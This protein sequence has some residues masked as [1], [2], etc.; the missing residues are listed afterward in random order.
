MSDENQRP[1]DPAAPEVWHRVHPL[2]P[3]LDSLGVLVAIVI[4]AAYAAQ[5]LV[6]NALEGLATGEGVDLSFAGWLRSHPLV[7]LA[8]VG[9][10]VLV[11]L[12]GGLISWLA[13]KVMGYRLEADALY[14]RSGLFVKKQRKARLDRVQSI[15]L[16]QKLL[17][18]VFGL[19]ELV[20]DVAGGSD[21]N[22]SLKYLSRRRA[23]VLRDELLAAV[24]AVKEDRSTAPAGSSTA[25]GPGAGS[26]T[27]GPDDGPDTAVETP[28]V[29]TSV[30]ERRGDSVGV[31]VTKRL[32]AIAGGAVGEVEDSLNEMLA[33]YQVSTR[34]G[35]EGEIIR[36]P[37][38]RVVLA[39]LLKTETLITVLIFLGMFVAVGVLLVLGLTEVAIPLLFGVIPG[40]FAA[41]ATVRKDFANA[42][43]AVRMTDSGLAVSHGLFSVSRKVIP[44]DRVQAVCLHQPF[45]WRF[46]GWWR[47][48]YNIASGSDS[49]D[50]NL[51]LPV[52]DIDQALLMIGLALPDPQVADGIDARSLILS[53]MYDRRSTEP[54]AEAAE[55]RFSRQPR[56]SRL[57]DP[58]VYRR[59]AYT[60]TPAL[61]ILRLGALERRVDFV[62]HERVQSMQY[63]QGPLMRALGLGSVAVHSTAGP[64]RPQVTHQSEEHA[65]RFFH[66]HAQRTRLARQRFD[67]EARVGTE[68]RR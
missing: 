43:F 61:L 57:I 51:L 59:R 13:W 60:L 33:P 6:Q 29:D 19:A 38:H 50:T 16:R 11:L 58:L 28:G 31:R 46:T 67:A 5:N 12:V 39:S 14:A 42:N 35:D 21:S 22:V 32:S 66:E 47:A 49:A 52:G 36:V 63:R 65:L 53:A 48:E 15:D 56:S 68:D 9:G 10:I 44:L 20:F 7:V 18:R 34:L 41:A 40:L 64:I 62:P 1:A 54:D 25:V 26:V 2:T 3:I 37:V 8:G 45:L 27:D 30:P 17:P 24:R 23:E 4:G 55:A